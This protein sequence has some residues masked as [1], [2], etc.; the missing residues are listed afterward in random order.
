MDAAEEL[1][2]VRLFVAVDLDSEL[3]VRV[4]DTAAHLAEALRPIAGASPRWVTTPNLHVTLRFIGE[5][6]PER[7]WQLEALV[8]A[9]LDGA[10]FHLEL[11]GAGAFPASG[12][13]RVLWLGVTR[14]EAELGSLASRLDA[15]LRTAG[16]EAHDR[17]FRAHLTLA[18]FRRPCAGRAARQVRALLRTVGLVGTARVERVTL[19]ES[20]LASAGP[21]YVARAEGRLDARSERAEVA[22]DAG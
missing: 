20:R 9:P 4:A 18:R 15:R 11:A 12:A 1:R 5:V 8:S 6:A 10:P 21:T 7:V 14:G 17:P 3:R 2:P 22:E 19:Y 13:I 16:V